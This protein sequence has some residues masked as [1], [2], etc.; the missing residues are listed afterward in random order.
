MEMVFPLERG[1]YRTTVEVGSRRLGAGLGWIWL[2]GMTAGAGLTTRL[3]DF[4]TN[5]HE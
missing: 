5:R 4:A 2:L 3:S 1:A